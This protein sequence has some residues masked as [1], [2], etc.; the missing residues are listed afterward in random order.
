ME[1]EKQQGKEITKK[2]VF[3]VCSEGEKEDA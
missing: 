2:D 1:Q 3:V